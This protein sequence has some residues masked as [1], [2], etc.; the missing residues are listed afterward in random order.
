[1]EKVPDFEYFSLTISNGNAT[2]TKSDLLIGDLLNMVS[3]HRAQLS[4]QHQNAWFVALKPTVTD[5]SLE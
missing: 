2:D 4:T 3:I 1:M 5:K